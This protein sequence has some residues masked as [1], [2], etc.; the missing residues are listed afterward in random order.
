[1]A[2]ARVEHILEFEHLYPQTQ[3]IRLEQNYRSTQ[4]ILDA[5][6]GV[7]EHNRGRK[8]K[9]LWTDAGAGEKVHISASPDDES[10]GAVRDRYRQARGRGGHAAQGNRGPLPTNAQSRALEEACRDSSIPY[11]LIG[12]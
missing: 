8:G 9:R 6:N 7:I 4:T 12:R 10:E 5:A 1:V 3:V 2:R 11:Q